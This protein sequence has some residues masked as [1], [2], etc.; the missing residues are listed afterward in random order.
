MLQ[1]TAQIVGNSHKKINGGWK[2]IFSIYS[3]AAHCTQGTT[4]IVFLFIQKFL[5]LVE[6]GLGTVEE[7]L[8]EYFSHFAPSYFVQFV[9][10]LDT[11]ANSKFPHVRLV[12]LTKEN[13]NLFK[14]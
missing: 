3:W 1:Y 9:N 7:M 8:R 4:L 2:A 11:Y 13:I 10:C 12:F 14:C 5:A 6:V